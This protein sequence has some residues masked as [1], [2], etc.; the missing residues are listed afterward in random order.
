M[1]ADKDLW[2]M[3]KGYF[4][5]I[6]VYLW[7]HLPLRR[8]G[9]EGIKNVVFS[10]LPFLFRHARTYKNWQYTKRMK[11]QDFA[12]HPSDFPAHWPL[13]SI[14]TEQVRKAD[15]P[16]LATHPLAVI[17]HVFYEDIF[18]GLLK[19][20][21]HLDQTNCKLFV[22]TTRE[23][24]ACV[25]AMVSNT[26][27]ISH[28]EAF[29]NRGRDILSFIKLSKLAIREGHPLLLKLHTKRSDHRLSGELWRKEIYDKLLKPSAMKKILEIFE[30]NPK[31]GLLGPEGHV[32]PMSLYY[33]GNARAIGYLCYLLRM[34]P[35]E[36]REM[37]FVA[38]SMFYI[39]SQALM[40][41][42]ELKLTSELFEKEARQRDGTMAHAV[43][44]IFS[45]SNH[46]SGF[47]LADTSST[48]RNPRPKVIKDHP[49][50][51]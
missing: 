8:Q 10:C 1:E 17:I 36:L 42:L 9:K 2:Q 3:I 22:G 33:G 35:K 19:Y 48:S 31:V 13:E 5:R 23:K 20:L 44:R 37:H 43:E 26:P 24:L 41:L 14:D 25:R 4:T 45:V 29:E 27:F 40:P 12:F 15:R 49:Y 11:K 39:R 16:H 21:H 38:G 30:A 18:S 34:D 46:V 28:V 7:W 6:G 51:W 32:I 50:T 47:S